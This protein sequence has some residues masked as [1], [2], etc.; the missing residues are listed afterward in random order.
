MQNRETRAFLISI[1]LS[2][3]AFFSLLLPNLASASS[4]NPQGI[5]PTGSGPTQPSTENVKVEA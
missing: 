3:I 1:G 4:P 5:G 2:L